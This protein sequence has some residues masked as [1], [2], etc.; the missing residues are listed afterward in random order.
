MTINL[1]SL[2]NP[3]IEQKLQDLNEDFEDNSRGLQE[4]LDHSDRSQGLGDQLLSEK[5]RLKDSRARLESDKQLLSRLSSATV[6]QA[7]SRGVRCAY[8]VIDFSYSYDISMLHNGN[9]LKL[10]SSRAP[11]I[12]AIKEA[13][14]NGC[15]DCPEWGLTGIE[16]IVCNL[17]R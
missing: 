10:C 3:V 7:Y 11:I 14:K 6:I 15:R 2:L 8:L 5:N 13:L 17:Q 16:Q 9:F 1:F 4:P 12:T